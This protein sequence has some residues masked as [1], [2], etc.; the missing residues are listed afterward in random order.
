MCFVDIWYTS[1][2]AKSEFVAVL[3]LRRSVIKCTWFGKN[4]DIPKQT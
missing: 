3:S 1:Y 2:M 4:L